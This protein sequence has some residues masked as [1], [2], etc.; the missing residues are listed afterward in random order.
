M[1]MGRLKL[2][3]E[4]GAFERAGLQPAVENTSLVTGFGSSH[5]ANART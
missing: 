1:I 2:K 4:I 3:D 5:P